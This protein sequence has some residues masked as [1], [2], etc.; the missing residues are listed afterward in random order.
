MSRSPRDDDDRDGERANKPE[1]E[2]RTA[3][4][5]TDKPGGLS[6]VGKAKK[7]T[8]EREKVCPFLLRT[9]V[10]DGSFH[11][12]EGFTE[13]PPKEDEIDFHTWKD[14]TLRELASLIAETRP[15]AAT[16]QAKISFKLLYKDTQRGRYSF[17]DIGNVLNAR[18]TP[19][20]NKTLS[21]VK[22]QIGDLMSIA[23]FSSG[24]RPA[25]GPGDRGM[26]TGPRG[27][28]DMIQFGERDRD[29]RP[30]L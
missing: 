14:C 26:G 21:D 16:R 23:I 22:L 25:E 30:G 17:T 28:R 27:P 3:A 29:T 12:I 8:V 20:D 5:S 13:L 24:D 18:T 19:D 11:R 9:F 1:I 2:R 6:F 4:E 10:R 15:S 7:F